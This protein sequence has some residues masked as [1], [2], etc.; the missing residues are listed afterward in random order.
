MRKEIEQLRKKV[1]D[2]ER[3]LSGE[4]G[5]KEDGSLKDAGNTEEG[6]SR[7]GF[8][9]KAGL[10]AASLGVMGLSSVSGLK[11]ETS[12]D[13]SINSDL[14]LSDGELDLKGSNIVNAGEVKA[15]NLVNRR[16]V[17]VN[18]E[19]VHISH[20]VI[21]STLPV[22]DIESSDKITIREGDVYQ[23]IEGS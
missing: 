22:S 14:S 6:M 4:R 20:R 19:D 18:G 10:G 5:K 7:R 17:T 12:G 8:L 13:F 11:L 23:R 1:N 3:E 15:E 2:L 21:T 16:S 9:K